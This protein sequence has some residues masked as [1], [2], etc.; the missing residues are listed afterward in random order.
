LE[1]F[2]AGLP[3]WLDP[4]WGF[5]SDLLWLWALMPAAIALVRLRLVVV[6]QA[7]AALAL[8]ALLVIWASRVAIGSCP[9]LGDAIFGTS[10]APRFPATRVAEATA[11]IVTV[12][13]HLARPVRA[14]GRFARSFGAHVDLAELLVIN[15]SVSLL[16]SFIPV[17]AGIGVAEFGLT[18]GLT[19][20]GM[21]PEAAIAAVLLYRI[22]TYYLP[23]AW[24]FPA[25]LWL[26]RNRYL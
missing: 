10:R 14:F 3:G 1:T 22:S 15:I 13:P 7:L 20:A 6:A 24:G 23:P 4:V 11:L 17:P 16:A 9:A 25:M 12:S 2:F 19:S 18:I 21:I 26:Q 8:G 5:L